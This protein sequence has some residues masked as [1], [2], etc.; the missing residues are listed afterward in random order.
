[1]YI[2][3]GAAECN[4]QCPKGPTPDQ[5]GPDC[6]PVCSPVGARNE[7]GCICKPR[8][9]GRG[10]AHEACM[11]CCGV[12]STYWECPGEGSGGGGLQIDIVGTLRDMWEKLGPYKQY[13][14][15]ALLVV[16]LIKLL[17]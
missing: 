9:P 14:I 4:V 8:S 1:M 2:A 3:L 10:E 16:V 6:R 13:V 12:P 5:W 17:K 7:Q 15:I 11:R